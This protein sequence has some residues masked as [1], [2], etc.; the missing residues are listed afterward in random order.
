MPHVVAF[1]ILPGNAYAFVYQNGEKSEYLAEVTRRNG[2]IV[3]KEHTK[4]DDA[5]S[6]ARTTVGR[7]NGVAHP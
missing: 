4:P 2:E 5:I 3:Q 1:F 7:R 6:W